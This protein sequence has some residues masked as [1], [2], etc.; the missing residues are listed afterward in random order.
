MVRGRRPAL[1]A[2]VTIRRSNEP[3]F[4]TVDGARPADLA[5]AR[6]ARQYWSVEPHWCTVIDPSVGLIH[7]R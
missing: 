7:V 1:W 5:D 3:M 6:M 4:W 2:T